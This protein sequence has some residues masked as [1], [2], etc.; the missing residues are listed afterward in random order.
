MR[1]APCSTSG[2][3]PSHAGSPRLSLGRHAGALAEED[4][5]A[6]T[7][8]P[9]SSV[10]LTSV[11]DHGTGRARVVALQVS[12]DGDLRQVT[13]WPLGGWG[14]PTA[15]TLPLDGSRVALVAGDVRGVTV[16]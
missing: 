2:P 16:D 6:V 4:P 11:V 12:D 15:R 1:R 3:S 10:A 5:R 14:G 9:E 13:S 7:W 8:L